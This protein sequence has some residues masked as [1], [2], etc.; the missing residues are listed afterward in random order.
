MTPSGTPLFRG[1][2][3]GTHP[4]S[5]CNSVLWGCWCCILDTGLCLD[6]FSDSKGQLLLP[7]QPSL[8]LSSILWPPSSQLC[9]PSILREWRESHHPSPCDCLTRSSISDTQL[10]HP[11][12]SLLS[13]RKAGRLTAPQRPGRG[14]QAGRGGGAAPEPEGFI[15]CPDRSL[16]FFSRWAD[17]FS[18]SWSTVAA[19]S[20]KTGG[21]FN[22]PWQAISGVYLSYRVSWCE[23]CAKHN[24]HIIHS[25]T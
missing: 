3:A 2:A 13:D 10:C 22:T 4:R 11:E 15:S 5:S 23:D 6:R 20:E 7:L 9:E 18:T 1:V 25:V 16:F 17:G 24:S 21:C 14:E 12:Q 8:T 19:S